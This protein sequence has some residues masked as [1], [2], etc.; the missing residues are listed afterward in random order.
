MI[1]INFFFNISEDLCFTHTFSWETLNLGAYIHKEIK[2][3][4][5]KGNQSWVFIRRA[6]DEAEAPI[7]WPPDAKSWLSRKDPDAGKDWGQEEKWTTEDRGWDGWMVSLT[8][9]T[10]GWTSSQI[11]WRT[12][13][14]CM[15]QSMGLQ[16]IRH[17]WVTEQHQHKQ[18]KTKNSKWEYCTV[19]ESMR[20]QL[21]RYFGQFLVWQKKQRSL[22]ELLLTRKKNASL[23]IIDSLL[24]THIS[25]NSKSN[26][27]V[28]L[29]Y[30]AMR[31]IHH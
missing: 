26:N 8:Q 27:L 4:N 7:L 31:S 23:L 6:D 22:T 14:P 3:V 9:W 30:F 5:P 15:L 10:W 25:R 21:L 20:V 17:D 11:G 29:L 24:S 16:R 12:G 2:P 18:N 1:I 19:I 13:K 28:T